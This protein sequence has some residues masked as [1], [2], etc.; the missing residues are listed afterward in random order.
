MATKLRMYYN[1]YLCKVKLYLLNEKG[2]EEKID[3]NAADKIE[4]KFC[5]RFCLEDDLESLLEILSDSY[6]GSRLSI[7]FIGTEEN[8]LFFEKAYSSSQIELVKSTRQRIL[9]CEEINKKITEKVKQLKHDGYNID[10][11]GEIDKIL[12]ATIP[13][14][15][16]GNMSAGKSTFL[17]A[18]IGEE[19]LPSGQNRTTGINCALHN[20]QNEC[21]VRYSVSDSIVDIDCRDLSASKGESLIP[22]ELMTLI[23]Q[24]QKSINRVRRVIDYFN[25]KN[26]EMKID[27]TTLVDDKLLN[28]YCPFY[29]KEIPEQIVFYD[30]P[31]G[32]SDIYKD[33][34]I[35]LEK[36]LREQPKGFLIF[37]CAERKDLDKSQGLIDTIQKATGNKLDL[38][39]T[40]VICNHT[41]EKP[42]RNI[43]TSIEKEWMSRI[44]YVSSAVALGARKPESNWQETKLSHVFEKNI[45][46]FSDPNVKFYTS[47]PKECSLPNNRKIGITDKEE[48]LKNDLKVA[49]DESNSKKQ[50]MQ[51][52]AGITTVEQEIIY[53]AKELFPYN[54]CERARN[55]LLELLKKY[56]ADIKEK[57]D[58]KNE[59]REK[60]TVE[61]ELLYKPLC[62]KLNKLTDDYSSKA[63]AQFHQR[64]MESDYKWSKEKA[65]D[66]ATHAVDSFLTKD[67]YSEHD[68]SAIRENIANLINTDI[69]N[70]TKRAEQDLNDFLANTALSGYAT[71][72][73]KK[74][75]AQAELSESEKKVFESFFTAKNL[76]D[77]TSE[78]R[79]NTLNNVNL[80]IPKLKERLS[81]D[82]W[83]TTA[84]KSIVNA[85]KS[86]KY[87][88]KKSCGSIKDDLASFHESTYINQTNDVYT[89]TDEIIKS[90]FEEI[91]CAFK[92]ESANDNIICDL[93]PALGDIMRVIQELNTELKDLDKKKRD[94]ENELTELNNV[95][96][97]V[98]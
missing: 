71:E 49:I 78:S 70:F 60:R 6:R 56:M 42:D 29:N 3:G 88:I 86:A 69:N 15:V 87:F 34:A 93:K 98:K 62:E 50:L 37:V 96:S 82:E 28:V 22:P 51:F 90:I 11:N 9:S 92:D 72:C 94:I 74:I 12:D 39:H 65:G 4:D 53:V 18:L 57:T 41:E 1:P 58:E 43:Q 25:F 8:F 83:F 17:N 19:L 47:L 40:I 59:Q 80:N 77:R 35:T 31:G 54:Q 45:S 95:F 26:D 2:D 55:V 91:N 21:R 73:T 81:G 27:R 85:G 10:S 64:I 75:N 16:V 97:N 68:E 46:A 13:V 30:T 66:F 33:D 20:S 24:E 32:D 61:F 52:N 79:K 48:K 23:N 44:I 76:K 63:Q 89:Q 84:W 14:V 67:Y 5:K 7:D 38:A 36:A